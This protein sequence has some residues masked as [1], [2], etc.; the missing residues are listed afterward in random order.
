[1]VNDMYTA[2]FKIWQ[3]VYVPQLLYKPNWFRS[4]K[5]LMEGDLLLCEEGEQ[6]DSVVKGRDSILREVSIKYCNSSE[7]CWSLTG[8]SSKDKTLPMYTEKAI[9]KMRLSRR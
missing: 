5:D 6:V 2:L 4:D 1:M 7:Q 3:D 8:N 9:R